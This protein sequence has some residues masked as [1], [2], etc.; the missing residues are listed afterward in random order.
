LATERYDSAE[1]VN[2]GAGREVTIRELIATIARLCGYT[3]GIA[4]DASQPDGQPRRMLDVTRAR[5]RFGFEA[6]VA[7][8]DGLRRTISW[9]AARTARRT[10]ATAAEDAAADDAQ[11]SERRAA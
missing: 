1:P 5:E 4:W 8:E 7:L 2:I 3:G 10:T 9:Y 11:L 6:Q